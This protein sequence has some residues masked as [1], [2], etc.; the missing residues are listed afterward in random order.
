MLV[1]AEPGP[2]GG[3][4][5]DLRQVGADRHADRPG[6]RR[7]HLPGAHH[8]LVVAAIP[9]QRLVDDC[10][11]YQPEARESEAARDR[12]TAVPSRPPE[13]R[14]PRRRWSCCSTPRHREQALGLRAVRL[15]VQASTVLGPAATPACSGCPG[16]D[17]RARRDGGLQRRGW[18]R[19]TPTRAARPPSPRRRATSPAPAPGRSASPT[20]STSATRRSPRSSSSSA[21]PAA[22]S[23]TRAGRSARRSPA[24][25]SRSTT[26]ARPARSIPTPT[27]GMVGLLEHAVEAGAEPLRPRRG[28]RSSSWARPAASWAARPT[29]PRSAI[30][31]AAR[32]P[33]ST[34]RP[35]GGCSESW[36]RRPARA[37]SARR[38]TA[39]R[40]GCWSRWPRRRSAART[41]PARSAPSSTSTGYAP[42][43]E[44]EALLFGEDAGRVVVSADPARVGC[45]GRARPA[46]TACPL[47]RAGR[48][49][50]AAAGTSGGVSRVQLGCPAVA[51]KDLLRSDPSAHAARRRGALGGRIDRHVRHHRRLRHSGRGPAHLPRPLRPA[52]PRAGERR[53]SSPSIARATL[54]PTAAWGW[55]PR[56]S[57]MPSWTGSP[58]T[59]PSATPATP[60]PAAPCSPTRSPAASTPAA[61]RSPSPTTATSP[62][63][64]SSSASW[65][66][67]ARSSR[68]STDTEV[69]VH[70]IARSDADT[71]EDQIRDA[72]EQVEGAYSLVI[73]V[74]RTLY[75]VVDSRGLPPAG[76]R[77]AGRRHRGRLGDLRARPGRRDLR[78]RAPAGRL[79]PDRRRARSPSCPASRPG[80]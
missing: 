25:T 40:A 27:I 45:P 30:S 5:G 22:A 2:G 19:S 24:A 4:P 41:R 16:T 21:R 68:R 52:A 39:P 65:S 23:P 1:V 61:A 37:C 9:G 77:P 14:S 70:L 35:S 67:R 38:T 3:G 59:S 43:V 7:R 34:S 31:S 64:P 29:G 66:R 80:R 78:L 6:D 15:H 56:T 73:T 50:G 58:A 60:P 47:F 36:W 42:G 71:V 79:R 69:L 46:S 62:T 12:R 75:A 11:I 13:G 20:A 17:V 74:G 54:V 26:R 57:T 10:P 28:T 8:G 48:A 49:G 18:S 33:R 55:S 53:A 63:P 44:L 51:A 32:P 76:H 72:L